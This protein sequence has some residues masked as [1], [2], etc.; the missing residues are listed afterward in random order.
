MLRLRV[1]TSSGSNFPCLNFVPSAA[2]VWSH[3]RLS[4]VAIL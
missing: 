1:S 4:S 3:R 2:S